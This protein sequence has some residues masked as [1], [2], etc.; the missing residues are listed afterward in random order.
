MEEYAQSLAQASALP[1]YNTTSAKRGRRAWS[2]EADDADLDPRQGK[3]LCSPFPPSRPQYSN[4][5]CQ[6]IAFEA[7][8]RW[9]M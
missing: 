4:M 8:F 2:E 5:V 7:C 1:T 9:E 6:T 3:P